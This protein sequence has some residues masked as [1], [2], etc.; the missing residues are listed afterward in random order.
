[1]IKLCHAP[2]SCSLVPISGSKACAVGHPKCSRI[3]GPSHCQG[4]QYISSWDKP[5]WVLDWK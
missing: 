5:I 4:P 1:M 2:S 3:P